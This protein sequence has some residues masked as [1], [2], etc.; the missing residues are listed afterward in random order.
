MPGPGA[1]R[2]A[3]KKNNTKT[4]SVNLPTPTSLSRSPPLPPALQ[5]RVLHSLDELSSDDW[6]EV[7]RVI[8]SH[9]KVPG[10]SPA[11]TTLASPR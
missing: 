6:D 10:M 5:P 1:K 2:S 11:R 4:V 3:A 9:L 8:C 7:V